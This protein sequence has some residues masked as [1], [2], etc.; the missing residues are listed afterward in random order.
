MTEGAMQTCLKLVLEDTYYR[1][2]LKYSSGVLEM[3][4]P[5]YYTTPVVE[6]NPPEPWRKTECAANGR[7]GK[8]IKAIW[9]SPEYHDKIL[10]N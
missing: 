5:V 2:V 6:W 3:L 1:L 8:M 4:V 9:S 10:H 7:V